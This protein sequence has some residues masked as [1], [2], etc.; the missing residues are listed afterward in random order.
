MLTYRSANYDVQRREQNNNTLCKLR[1]SR[2][3]DGMSF[4]TINP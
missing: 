3:V 2:R 1:V 4:I